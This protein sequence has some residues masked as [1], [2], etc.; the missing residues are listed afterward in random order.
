MRIV[1]VIT[2]MS[3][4]YGAQKHTIECVK[5][6][7]KND[8]EC[9]V[10][11]GTEGLAADEIRKVGVNVFIIPEL[12][13]N[14]DLLIDLKVVSKIILI[15]AEFNPNLVISHSSK[16]GVLSRIACF[17]TKTPNIFTVHGWAFESGTPLIQ[18][19]V[20]QT[21]ELL[22][23]PISDI[24]V[25]VSR[26]TKQFG[27]SKLPLNKKRVF[28]CPNMHEE[29]KYKASVQSS[30]TNNVLMVGGFRE[31]K[32]HLTALKALKIIVNEKRL[33][34]IHFTFVGD[35]N[36]RKVIVDYINENSLSNFV[37]LA[38]ETG[39]VD[40]YYQK[41][42][43]VILPTYY[44]GLPLTLIEA[45]Q[46]GKPII[47]T[48]TGGIKEI[49]LDNVNGNLIG[50]E[51][52]V[53]LAKHITNYYLNNTIQQMSTNALEIYSSLYSY[54]IVSES[55]V[56]IINTALVNSRFKKSG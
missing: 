12:K 23:I 13:N 7:L 47:A 6:H 19:I 28:A 34:N 43:I 22:L 15:I 42:D 56:K 31:Q 44:E 26:H 54:E 25:C 10:I 50:I 52:S 40:F 8:D 39:N 37:T 1:H 11:A 24:Y 5:F 48:D 36:K 49:V 16:A 14:Y 32:D 17:K 4:I 20:A 29:K 18:K 38:G 55:L 51:D 21:I 9:I 27:L 2:K 35:G 30:L 53:S 3:E 33:I 41:A 45:L 46:Y